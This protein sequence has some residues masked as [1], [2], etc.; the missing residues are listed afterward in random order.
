MKIH[1]IQERFRTQI[2]QEKRIHKALK[3]LEENRKAHQA[4]LEKIQTDEIVKKVAKSML[5]PMKRVVI[6]RTGDVAE[7]S[8]QDTILRH[9]GALSTTDSIWAPWSQNFRG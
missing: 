1:N 3:I 7:F 4:E 9:E 2:K 5:N 8:A 6:T